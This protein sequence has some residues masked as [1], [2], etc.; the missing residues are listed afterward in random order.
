M[1]AGALN[2]GHA[3]TDVRT[4]RYVLVT[5]SLRAKTMILSLISEPNRLAPRP[6]RLNQDNRISAPLISDYVVWHERS[7]LLTAP[8]L[9][10]WI[11][12]PIRMLHLPRAPIMAS[13]LVSRVGCR[14]KLLRT[15]E[16]PL[17]GA[18]NGPQ[19]G[20]VLADAASEFVDIVAAQLPSP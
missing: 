14:L 12:R 7:I 18:G 15:S 3:L 6:W 20:D 17:K 10:R 19:T 9:L 1:A 8:A 2:Y 5:A 16:G 11:G 4:A 13:K